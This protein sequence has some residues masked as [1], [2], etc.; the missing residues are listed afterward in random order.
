MSDGDASS[1]GDFLRSR[2]EAV[3]PADVG[4]P[5]GPRR[6]TPG[7]RRSEVATLAG[8]SVEYL[9][10]IEQ[11][12][13][14]HPSSQ[15]LGALADALRLSTDDR[16]LLMRLMKVTGGM[17]P[18]P[19]PVPPEQ[20]V[21]RTVRA[22]LD[23]LE[24]SPAFVQNRLGDILAVTSGF[25]ALA[26]PLGLLDDDRPNLATYVFLDQRAR[27]A[28]PDWDVV[29]DD[30][31]AALRLRIRSSDEHLTMLVEELKITAG[32]AFTSRLS[33]ALT[34]PRRNGV[35]RV[36]H[37]DA[38]ELRLS[39]EQLELPDG[40]SLMAY[41]PA[42]AAAEAALDRL[43]GRRPRTLRVVTG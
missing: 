13:D 28:F 31:A 7:L 39:F 6:R 38:G 42:D 15:V 32:S 21:R 26:G 16:M 4:L 24:P 9:T 22:L 12:R 33:G 3:R 36:V 29:A 34:M 43:A 8:I 35:L 11:G 14:R 41:L 10:R 27:T 5:T 20:E 25:D 37:P 1:I 18:C 2:R 30:V 17:G 23:R 19:G 40:Q